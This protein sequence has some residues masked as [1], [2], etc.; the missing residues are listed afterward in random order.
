MTTP[1]SVSPFRSAAAEW[2]SERIEKLDRQEMEQLKAN[3]MRL[4]EEG[5]AALCDAALANSPKRRQEPGP[6]GNKAK[7]LISRRAAF[8]A[9]GVYLQD[10]RTSWGGVRKSDGAVVLALW[11]DA[12]RSREGGCAY[13][14]WAPNKD[15]ASPWSE[16]ASGQERLKHCELAAAGAPVEGLLVFGEGLAGHAPEHKAR[17]VFGVDPET[18]VRFTVEKRDGEYWAVWGKRA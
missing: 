11:A 5:V 6:K 3:A 13:R 2:T 15:G 7:R 1:S 9:R 4:G 10:P 17:S 18:T 12:V 8:E 16:T 14:L